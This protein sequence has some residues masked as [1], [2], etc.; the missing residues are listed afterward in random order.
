MFRV[1][2]NTIHS[3][4]DFEVILKQNDAIAIYFSTEYCNVCKVLKPKV[5]EFLDEEFPKVVFKY[6]DIEQQKEIAGNYSIFAVPT[7][8]FFFGGKEA[9]RKSR[10]FGIAELSD[11]IERPYNMI[12]S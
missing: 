3:L 12:F 5:K 1:E 10:N 11:A 8:V 4:E 9:F 6:V 7:I 2:N